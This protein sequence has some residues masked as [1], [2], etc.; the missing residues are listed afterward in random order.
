MPRAPVGP[1]RPLGSNAMAAA[2][3]RALGLCFGRR[4]KSM[5]QLGSVQI[6]CRGRLLVRAAIAPAP[7]QPPAA[8]ASR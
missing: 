4:T 3:L 6:T 2:Q 1:R 8:R 5:L 7:D